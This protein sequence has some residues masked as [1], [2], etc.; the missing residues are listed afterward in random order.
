[1]WEKKEDNGLIIFKVF[2]I[3]FGFICSIIHI[4]GF[5]NK[6]E[7]LP[8][9]M[10]FC[11]A[12]VTFTLIPIAI[13]YGNC[14]NYSMPLS[15][16]VLLCT[17]GFILFVSTSVLSMYHVEIDAHMM[18]LTD[19][20]EWGHYYFKIN[21]FQC[22]FSLSTSIIYLLNAVLAVDMMV[23]KEGPIAEE[24]VTIAQSKNYKYLDMQ[25]RMP[26]RINKF[27]IPCKAACN[28]VCN[29]SKCSHS[30]VKI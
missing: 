10:V 22:I 30:E 19:F 3:I 9:E 11:G 1:M 24:Q 25:A 8:H 7:Q 17:T 23:I 18:F 29:C 21:R 5:L 20:E 16:D 26:L 4:V 27:W 12:Y 14:R 15:I 2:G 6:D 28:Q 13:V